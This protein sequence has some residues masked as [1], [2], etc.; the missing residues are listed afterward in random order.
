MPTASYK[1]K[2][3]CWKC[4]ALFEVEVEDGELVSYQ[5]I[6][7]AE[8]EKAK[9]RE[10]AEKKGLPYT[11]PQASPEAP[12]M[13]SEASSERPKAG[14]KSGLPKSN[15]IVFA[16]ANPV[17]RPES[18][19]MRS[20][21]SS[22]RPKAHAE[23]G[24]PKSN[25]IVF[26]SA[27][28]VTKPESLV[29]PSEASSERPKAGVKSGLPKSNGIVFAS[30][31]PV[32]R[33]EAPVM[34]SGASSERPK[35]HAESGL[36]KNKRSADSSSP[37]LA[38]NADAL[39]ALPSAPKPPEPKVEVPG[40]VGKT[41][42]IDSFNFGFI[43]VDGKQYMCDVVILPDGRVTEREPGR[44][45]IGSHS[46]TGS[47][48]EPLKITNPEI[49]VVGTGMRGMAKLSEPRASD[50]NIRV[51]SSQ[52]AVEEFNKL[53]AEGKRVAALIHITC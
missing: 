38:A 17:T 43:V 4:R 25:G 24:L 10:E 52:T 34:P 8:L 21:A 28:A 9:A 18:L 16:S 27:N 42:K 22:E 5:P 2:Y 3:R 33:P 37:D 6:T 47:Q 23:S 40:S 39:F 53:A 15:G 19:V 48:L 44:G 51:M 46:I 31:N 35:A 20:G 26:A 14:V 50:I 36:P 45:R 29:M 32:T 13:P 7:E 12:V 41:V 11:R 30:A 1:G 49:I